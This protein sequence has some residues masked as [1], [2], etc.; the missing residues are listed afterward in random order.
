MHLAV[1]S[2][3]ADTPTAGV[4]AEVWAEVLDLPEVGTDDNFLE[5]GGHSLLATRVIAR[6][7]DR[8]G[9]VLTADALLDSGSLGEFSELV[10]AAQG[11]LQPA[12]AASTR[13][14]ADEGGE[15]VLAPTQERLWFVHRLAPQSPAYTVLTVERV[16]GPVSPEHL[17]TALLAVSQRHEVLRWT[18]PGHAGRPQVVVNP[19][20]APLRVDDLR[21][22]PEP[23]RTAAAERILAEE[24]AD[25]VD[26]EQGPMWRVRLVRLADDEQLLIFAVHHI[27]FDGWSIEVLY[28]DLSA[29]Y[30]AV[31]AAGGHP[32]AL[33]P[34]GY[35]YA[36]YARER[37]SDLEGDGFAEQLA[38]WRERLA[39]VPLVLDL[40]R[41]R[42]RP[43]VQTY[44]GA[45][46]S[47]ILPD[48]VAAELHDLARACGVTPFVPLLS[49]FGLLLG[50]LAGVDDLLVGTPVAGRSRTEHEDLVG[51]FVDT[52]PVRI[53]LTCAPTGRDLVR[54]VGESLRGALAHQELPFHRL[55]EEL[56]PP[57]DP[58]RSPVVQV[59]FNGYTYAEAN[60]SLP[61]TSSEPV[62]PPLTG[63]LFDLTMYADER[64]G[65]PLR[66][67]HAGQLQLR[68]V[69]N[70][71][72][73]DEDRMQA[74][75]AQYVRLLGTLVAQPDEQAAAY[76]LAAP[77]DEPAA[78]ADDY[79]APDLREG[80]GSGL[81]LDP[82][83]VAVADGHRTLHYGELD[84]HA[85]RL[86][87]ALGAAGVGPGD[88]VAIW[89]GRTVALPVA[90][91]G[92]LRAGVAFTVLDP[93]YPHS[94]LA[95]HH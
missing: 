85:H 11:G 33:P 15:R 10:D 25:P 89:A 67:G 79:G 94:P 29:A 91:L 17:R 78:P 65:G 63:S 52:V 50:R 95:P 56:A 70:P 14:E 23:E 22:R 28:R 58:S 64:G 81:H 54:R 93:S 75:L 21:G 45:E 84:L 48:T 86:A 35:G 76:P 36:D 19:P 57:R 34:L 66:S 68:L 71:D 31:A 41:D 4:V 43:A 13:T 42:A 55:V 87:S 80:L 88:V 37:R 77:A 92:V 18:F 5:C 72:L 49:G 59:L 83:A 60:L 74:L 47:A 16:H 6:L 1:M 30:A 61:G 46:E 26:L 9:V 40:P 27:V 44:R 2:A 38:Y 82:T 51:F 90:L 20:A 12:A 53:D 32:A 3:R 39:G 69:Y 7:R 62:D 24:A 73:Y 8:L